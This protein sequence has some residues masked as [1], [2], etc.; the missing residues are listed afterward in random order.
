MTKLD[1]RA[2]GEVYRTKL[3]PNGR[4]VIP[5]AV[6]RELGL[7]PGDGILMRMEPGELGDLRV[8]TLERAV[9]RI[10]RDAL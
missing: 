5:R 8:Y 7:K 3:G 6:R 4:I 9:K 10:Q 2:R 1:M